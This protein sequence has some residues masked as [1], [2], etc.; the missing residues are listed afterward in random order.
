MEHLAYPEAD[1]STR[2]VLAQDHSID[3]TGRD[4]RLCIHQ[5]KPATL[6]VALWMELE[7]ESYQLASRQRAQYAREAQLENDYPVQRQASMSEAREE[8]LRQLVKVFQGIA[9]PKCRSADQPTS[10]GERKSATESTL[11]CWEC[12]KRDH[13]AEATMSPATEEATDT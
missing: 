11:V 5:N 7:L 10:R 6:R 3:A 4:M 13:H 2:K 12:N 9:R 1:E 8:V